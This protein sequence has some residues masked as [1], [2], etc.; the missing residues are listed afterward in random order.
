MKGEQGSRPEVHVLYELDPVVPAD[1]S[2]PA[3]RARKDDEP[4][5]LDHVRCGHTHIL[6]LT[7]RGGYLYPG[8][9]MAQPN[10]PRKGEGWARSLLLQALG[11]MT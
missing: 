1:Q 6:R 2:D 3:A 10:T 7:G 8:A 4:I 5:V 11:Q 9:Q